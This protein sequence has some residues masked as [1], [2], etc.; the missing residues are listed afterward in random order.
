MT[1]A[2]PTDRGESIALRLAE[3]PAEPGV[4]LMKDADGRILYVGKARNLRKRL[5]NYFKPSGHGDSR[6][7]ALVGRIADFETVLTRTADVKSRSSSRTL[8]RP[9]WH[10][11]CARKW[12]NRS[13]DSLMP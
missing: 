7:E 5:A 10:A 4:Y 12:H 11:I 6:I 13:G 3:A 2:L 1:T 9:H 8:S